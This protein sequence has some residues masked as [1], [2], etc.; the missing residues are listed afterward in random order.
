MARLAS[1]AAR[2]RSSTASV[3]IRE[4]SLTRMVQMLPRPGSA[5]RPSCGS[6]HEAE[7]QPPVQPRERAASAWPGGTDASD[8]TQTSLL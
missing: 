2:N 5:T 6:H 1:D 7:H 3:E 8:A 4:V